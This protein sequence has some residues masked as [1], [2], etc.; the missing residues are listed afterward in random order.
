MES[1]LKKGVISCQTLNKV[2]LGI[3]KFC[4]HDGGRERFM[5]KG[6]KILIANIKNERKNHLF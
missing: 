6:N 2:M 4:G 5:T 1:R 3:A